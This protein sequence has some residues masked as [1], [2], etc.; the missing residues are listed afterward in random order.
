MNE[1]MAEL[2]NSN[3]NNKH[4]YIKSFINK[5]NI[6]ICDYNLGENTR[7]DLRSLLFNRKCEFTID[8]V[9]FEE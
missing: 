2:N 6:Y 7:M 4:I 8:C 9:C 1:C 5:C 3:N